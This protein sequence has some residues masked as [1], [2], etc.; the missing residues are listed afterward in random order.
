MNN[1]LPGRFDQFAALFFVGVG[2]LLAGGLNLLMRR[3]REGWRVAVTLVVCGSVIGGLWALT[4]DGVLTARAGRLLAVGVVPCLLLG[5]ARLGVAAAWLARRPALRWGGVAAAGL[6]IAFISTAVYQAAD[7]EAI[8]RY[9][10]DLDTL[11]AKPPTTT[12]TG[13]RATT[14][15]G[16]PI[17][18]QMAI[19]LRDPRAIASLEIRQ[20]ND[21]PIADQIIRRGPADDRCNCHGWVFTGGRYWLGTEDVDR[22]LK[23]NG[24]EAVTDP[25]PGDLALY[26]NDSQG[27]IHTAVVR[28][29][30][31]QM[32][33]L[34]EGKWAA[35][36]IYLH[37][38]DRSPYG[39][40]YTYYRSGRAG[41]LLAGLGGP[42]LPSPH[43]DPH[44]MDPNHITE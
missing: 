4:G 27:F 3:T 24:Y 2:M 18:V 37:P 26:R 28:Y 6:A 40:N 41:H 30:G 17:R 12:A 19:A 25:R 33:V 1:L 16:T 38:V 23:E 42:D 10:T 31:D 15:R 13:I 34:V 32:P 9:M 20:R 5:S 14:D 21:Q 44:G 8:S 7:D 35:G 43:P 22:I 29:V 11:N 36:S 39:E